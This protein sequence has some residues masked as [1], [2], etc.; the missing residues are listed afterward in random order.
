MRYDPSK[1]LTAAECLQHPYFQIRL[2]IPL[3]AKQD[4]EET[5]S[6]PAEEVGPRKSLEGFPQLKEGEIRRAE[7]RGRAKKV[8]AKEL[9]QNARYRP[10]V[11]PMT[12]RGSN[13]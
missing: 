6:K 1:R 13:N 10:G 9:M 5:K 8:T 11:R 12:L 3:S 7:G 4:E 2:P